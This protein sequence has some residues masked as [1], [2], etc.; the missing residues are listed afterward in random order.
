MAGFDDITKKAQAF[1]KDGKVQEALKSEKAEGV[2]DNILDAVAS[3]ADKATGGKHA[4]K[5]Q[6]AK[7]QADKKLGN[8]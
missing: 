6:Q 3:A 8:Q 7:E 2:S 4:D 5:I 1:L